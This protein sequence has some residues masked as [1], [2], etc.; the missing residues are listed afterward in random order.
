MRARVRWMHER[1]PWVH[2]RT[3]PHPMN[4]PPPGYEVEI[5]TSNGPAF[6][7]VGAEVVGRRNASSQLSGAPSSIHAFNRSTLDW[8]RGGAFWGMSEPQGGCV[9]FS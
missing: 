1:I 9:T 6:V 8:G 3:R 5:T 4:G 7:G 2:A